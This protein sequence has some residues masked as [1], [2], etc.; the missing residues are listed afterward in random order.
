MSELSQAEHAV[1][2]T[3]SSLFADV[4]GFISHNT[5][6]ATQAAATDAQSKVAAAASAVDGLIE[7]VADAALNA[8]LA[9]VPAGPEFAQVG[10]LFL[11][12]VIEKLQGKIAA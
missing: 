8:V 12:K 6:A 2:N 1:A 5:S 4:M 11:N 3:A 10:D 9:M 7:P